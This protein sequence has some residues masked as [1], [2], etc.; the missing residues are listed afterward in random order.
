LRPLR[1]F[2]LLALLQLPWLGRPVHYDEANFLTLARG[3]AADPW[4]PHDVRINWQGTEER[5]FDVL[6]N[7]PGIAW[8]LAP[9]VDAPVAARRLWMLPWL[10]LAAFGAVRLAERFGGAG[11]EKVPEDR[12][13]GAAPPAD[14]AP[15][16]LRFDR[17]DWIAAALLVSPIVMLS[18][19]ALLPDLPLYA[20][21]LAGVAGFVRATDTDATRGGPTP[22]VRAW[23]GTTNAWMWALVAGAGALFRYSA[24]PMA[25]LLGAYAVLSRRSPLPALAA[26]GPIGALALHDLHA[27]GKVHLL[28]MG[29]FQSVANTPED[30]FH[31]LVASVAMLGGAAALPIFP[32]S[33][34]AAG[35]AAGGA[36]LGAGWGWLGGAFGAAG[37]A[38][39][40]EVGRRAWMGLRREPSRP[41]VVRRGSQGDVQGS[42]T[43]GAARTFPR[44]DGPWLALWAFGGLLFLLTLRFTATRYWLPFLPAAL[45]VIAPRRPRAL[46]GASVVLGVALGAD[47]TFSARAQEE[48][49]GAA[50]AVGTGGF[51][52]HWG[53]QWALE[54]AGWRALDEGARPDAGTLVA[55]PRQ[56]WPQ[57]VDVRCDDVVWEGAAEPPAPWLPRAYTEAGGANLHASWIAGFPPRRTVAP[58]TFAA[59]P[60]E[61]AR[62]CRE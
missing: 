15:T 62:V 45:L 60:Y 43:G 49:A 40:G 4:R 27:Y 34:A 23:L 42:P 5:A 30:V 54:Q 7:P 35:G 16:L 58:W 11:G 50:A 41:V 39:L 2:A 28:A 12:M 59:D 47:D 32:W 44:S 51:T 53:W 55:L 26:L 46:V 48:L 18:S 10:L 52:G 24:L 29:S 19:T 9:M 57:P 3:A 20:L 13:R 31:K 25:P 17:I 6:S 33:A 14:A 37:G 1:L 61:A 22:G 56:A 21:T 8:W 36:V 38:V